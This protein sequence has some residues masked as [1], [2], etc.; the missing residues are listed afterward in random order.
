MP[1]ELH[2]PQPSHSEAEL[3][4]GIADI[5]MES[6]KLDEA[7]VTEALDDYTLRVKKRIYPEERLLQQRLLQGYLSL[8][9]TLS[10]NRENS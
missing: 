7:Q 6:F 10:Q 4:N 1:P 2:R 9:G 5:V 8:L 3:A